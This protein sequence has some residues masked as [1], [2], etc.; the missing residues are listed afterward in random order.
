[1]YATEK[2]LKLEVKD[3]RDLI[4]QLATDLGGDITH[5]HQLILAQ[6]RVITLLQEQISELQEY[7]K[8][9]Q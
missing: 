6:E 5:L 2:Y 9:K 4:K 3:L 8:D 7:T 1:M